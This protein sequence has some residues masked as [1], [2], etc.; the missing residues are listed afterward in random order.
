MWLVCDT[1]PKEQRPDQERNL[2][3]GGSSVH[4]KLVDDDREPVVGAAREPRR[5]LVEN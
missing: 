4:V 3:S 5:G 2:R 1:K